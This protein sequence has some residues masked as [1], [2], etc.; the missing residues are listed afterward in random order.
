M[1]MCRP[2]GCLPYWP[3]GQ[4]RAAAVFHMCPPGE[5]RHRALAGHCIIV[6][7]PLFM[8]QH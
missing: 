6:Y 7:A 5:Y 3:G 1:G 4:V 8:L 2:C